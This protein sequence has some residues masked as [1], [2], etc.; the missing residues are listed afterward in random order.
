MDLPQNPANGQVSKQ[1]EFGH[2][3]SLLATIPIYKTYLEIGTWKGNG[4]TR[5]VVD[6]ILERLEKEKGEVYFW[7]IEANRRFYEEAR[8]LWLPAALPFLHLLYGKVHSDGL[9][10]ASEV[11]AHP[12]FGHVKTHYELWYKQDAI[13]YEAAPTIRLDYL[14]PQ[15]DVVIL[16]GGEFC[17]YAD[18]LAVKTKNPKVV[19]LDDT[20]V[21]KNERVYK[22]LKADPQWVCRWDKQDRHGW[23]IF[24]RI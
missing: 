12:Y 20:G 14:P 11:E 8:A 22:E 15:I 21:M 2:I 18:W 19:C 9:M 23:A 17:G 10:S 6:G 13:D 7:S 1:T 4:T 5:C 3:L 24:E 16:D